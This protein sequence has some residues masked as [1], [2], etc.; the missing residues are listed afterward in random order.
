MS[1][2]LETQTQPP[3][4]QAGAQNDVPVVFFGIGVIINL[5]LVAV[6]FAWARKQWKKPGKE[7]E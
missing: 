5:V 2:I 7:D 4:A 1:E 3:T 6:Y